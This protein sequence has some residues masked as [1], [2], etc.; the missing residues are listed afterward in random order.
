MSNDDRVFA[1]GEGPWWGLT[2]E[3][4]QAARVILAAAI[5]LIFAAGCS[6]GV[7]VGYWLR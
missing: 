3:G 6:V 7:G 1:E 4:R 5:L 2:P